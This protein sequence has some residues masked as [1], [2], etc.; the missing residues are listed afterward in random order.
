MK[1]SLNTLS[2]AVTFALTVTSLGF[3]ASA[4]AVYT[5]NL[6]TPVPNSPAPKA[7]D[8]SPSATAKTW[9]VGTNQAY[10]TL[11]D[12][13]WNHLKAG[14]VVRVHWRA[15][16]YAEK[17]LLSAS[18][19]AAKPIKLC[20]VPGGPHDGDKLLPTI[21][22]ENAV[23]RAD[24]AYQNDDSGNYDADGVFTLEHYGLITIQHKTFELKPKNI[25]I[26]GLHLTGA[27]QFTSFTAANGKLGKHDR[28]TACI[29]LQKGDNVTIRGN[30]IE[31]CGH[32]V[33]A[34]SRDNEPQTSRNLLLES[35]YIHG[36]GA[37][38]AADGSDTSPESVHSMYIQ[39]IGMTAQFNY[40][41]PNRAGAP[42]GIFK[43]R[44]VGSVVRYNWF[45]EGA[46]ILDFVEPQSYNTSF[47]LKDYDA[48]V[49]QYGTKDMP[50]RAAVAKAYKQ[51]QK[52]YVY[53]NF[54]RNDVKAGGQ[55]AY[56]PVHFGGDEGKA[57]NKRVRQGRLYFFNN[58][59]LTIADYADSS[60]LNVFDMGYGSLDTTPATKIESFN[61]I[62]HLQSRHSD[63]PRPDYY[64]TRHDFENINLGKNWLTSDAQLQGSDAAEIA[65]LAG[66]GVID[67]VANLTGGS[68]SPVNTDTLI[69]AAGNAA[70]LNAGQALPAELAG[71]TLE[72]QFQANH[73]N[74]LLS[75]IL[76]RST[77]NDLGAAA[78]A[79]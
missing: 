17:I 2:K 70:L 55:G 65:G 22:G 30:E 7:V 6:S 72:Y 77:P 69:S 25:I 41:G 33:F 48:F 68:F 50:T 36:N 52:T 39:T 8:C 1:T 28:F 40:F 38:A 9:E 49:A 44:S 76:L 34:L 10:P 31:N 53:G 63:A 73:A 3:A 59:V 66:T 64:V 13:D 29:R 5:P 51:F 61:N 54:I 62:I 20:G 12:V 71:L 11:G 21:T 74:P 57:H 46:R 4:S 79:P 60:R 45:S 19:T 58:T 37:I 78:V 15:A 26:E 75:K 27:N 32:A 16:P 42:G 24:L 67:G 18:G 47:L 23:T 35:N 56:A 43:D 14:D